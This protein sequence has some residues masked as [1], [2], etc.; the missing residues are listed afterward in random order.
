MNLEKL[1]VFHGKGALELV[2]G[3]YGRALTVRGAIHAVIRGEPYARAIRRASVKSG[4]TILNRPYVETIR[5]KTIFFFGNAAIRGSYGNPYAEVIRRTIF[6]WQLA[7]RRKAIHGGHTKYFF[8]IY[9][10]KYKIL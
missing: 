1:I 7:I 9:F 5:K 8:L 3:T 4:L 6:Q 2:L 10:F